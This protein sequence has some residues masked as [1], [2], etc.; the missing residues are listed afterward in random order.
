MMKA[1]G[2]PSQVLPDAGSELS[3][4]PGDGEEG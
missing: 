2:S 4:G 3:N 1:F